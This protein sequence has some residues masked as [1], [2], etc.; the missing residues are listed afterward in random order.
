MVD[1]GLR[2]YGSEIFSLEAVIPFLFI[3][4][5][6]DSSAE[7]HKVFYTNPVNHLVYRWLR[8]LVFTFVIELSGYCSTVA[9]SPLPQRQGRFFYVFHILDFQI[10][11]IIYVLLK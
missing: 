3:P 2:E 8:T 5:S 11:R 10:L 4:F 6:Y 7:L 9:V 1:Q